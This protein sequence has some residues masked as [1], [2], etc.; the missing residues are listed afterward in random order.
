MDTEPR[1]PTSTTGRVDTATQTDEV[2]REASSVSY[3]YSP[4]VSP[5]TAFAQ[6]RNERLPMETKSGYF[7]F[8]DPLALGRR[9]SDT[10]EN[11]VPHGATPSEAKISSSTDAIAMETGDGIQPDDVPFGTAVGPNSAPPDDQGMKQFLPLLVDEPNYPKISTLNPGLDKINKRLTRAASHLEEPHTRSGKTDMVP[12][13]HPALRQAESH[14]VIDTELLTALQAE[15]EQLRADI[16]AYTW[17]A[18]STDSR[19][20]ETITRLDRNQDRLVTGWDRMRD[21]LL[22]IK[23]TQNQLRRRMNMYLNFEVLQ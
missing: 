21:E 3:D 7:I 20:G 10:P 5:D 9:I 13:I 17:L 14:P 6:H 8:P 23:V 19:L 1:S 12:K 18:R 16:Q 15:V 2:E 11:I 22:E 4:E